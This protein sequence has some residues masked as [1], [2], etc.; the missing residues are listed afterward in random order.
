MN[1]YET[2]EVN[3]E[4]I[5]IYY[6]ELDKYVDGKL[7]SRNLITYTFQMAMLIEPQSPVAVAT[8]PSV[9]SGIN[10]NYNFEDWYRINKKNIPFWAP[11]PKAD[12]NSNAN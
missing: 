10:I 3:L 9:Y 11:P 2:R 7:S 6:L 4:G 5:Y 1:G 12:V 8:P